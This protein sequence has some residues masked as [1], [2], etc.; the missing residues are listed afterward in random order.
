MLS[1]Y[2]PPVSRS[3]SRHSPSAQSSAVAADLGYAAFVERNRPRY[4]RYATIRLT[5]DEKRAAVV[6]AVLSAAR[7]HWGFI[8]SQPSPAAE[9]WQDLRRR[10]TELVERTASPAP[11][12]S[13]LYERFGDGLADSVVLCCRL[14]LDVDEAA[15]LMGAEP[16]TVTAS[17]AVAQRA[18][19]DLTFGRHLSR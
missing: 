15:D 13:A 1:P 6:T 16:P 4:L 8:L 14:G 9:V 18:L 11:E 17:L 19:P 7:E 2:G 10:V 5:V 3:A 12:V